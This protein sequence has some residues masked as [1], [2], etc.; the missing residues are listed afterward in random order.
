MTGADAVARRVVL[1]GMMGSGKSSVGRLL[2]ERTGWP[3]LDNDAFVEAAS[4]RTAREL[5]ASDADGL[6]RFE[7]DA[8]IKALQHPPAVI[9]G[10]AAGVVL[11]PTIG[12]LLSGSF[13]VWL[14]AEP[15]TLAARA[16]G[17][18]HRPWLDADA[19][20]WMEEAAAARAP[21][22]RSLASLEVWTED[23]SPEQVADEI[24]A[25]LPG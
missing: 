22:Y 14:R 15:A 10:A 2:S 11:D 24:L 25:A 1:I 23:R 16:A 5:A 3:Y 12:E 21:A 9:I 8:L 17:A 18:R 4:G 19:V 7:R 13:V 20:K 6:R